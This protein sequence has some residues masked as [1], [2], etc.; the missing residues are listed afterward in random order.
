MTAAILAAAVLAVV[1][2]VVVGVPWLW[3]R[4]AVRHPVLVAL[5]TGST[6]TG[7]LWRRRGPLLEVRD[8]TVLSAGADQPVKADGAVIIERRRVEFIQIAGDGS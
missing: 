5:D 1:A 7:V 6:V 8:V 2:A 4:A 3:W